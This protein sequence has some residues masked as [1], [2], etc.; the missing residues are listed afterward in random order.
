MGIKQKKLEWKRE[1]S[2]VQGSTI[3]R[4]INWDCYIVTFGVIMQYYIRNIYF[5]LFRVR[6]YTQVSESINSDVIEEE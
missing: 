2:I 4:K 6:I 5:R 1:T 3:Q